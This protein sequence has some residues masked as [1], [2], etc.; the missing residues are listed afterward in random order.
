MARTVKDVLTVEEQLRMVREEIEAQEGRLK[1][2]RDQVRYSTITLVMYKPV[3]YEG[4]PAIGFF[5]QFIDGIRQGCE[6]PAQCHRGHGQLLALVAAV[7]RRVGLRAEME[8][9]ASNHAKLTYSSLSFQTRPICH[10]PRPEGIFSY[11][12]PLKQVNHSCAELRA[13]MPSMK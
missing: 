2:L 1:F 9:P 4:E 3:P 7:G 10:F 11:L 6:W 13:C 8:K 12:Y 5:S